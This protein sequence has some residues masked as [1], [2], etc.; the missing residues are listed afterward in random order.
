[1]RAAYERIRSADVRFVVRDGNRRMRG[2]LV[3]EK[4]SVVRA[5]LDVEDYG[6]VRVTSD[7]QTIEVADPDFPGGIERLPWTLQNAR[8]SIAANLEVISL[9]DAP[10]Q[11]ST[12]EGGNM[13][14]SDLRI[15]ESE[16]WKGKRWTIL[17][18]KSGFA[19]YRYF[20]DP[21]TSLMWRTTATR[22]EGTVAYDGQ[23]ERLRV[24]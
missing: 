17:E 3:Y 6:L 14:G 18:E 12:G 7:G 15:G 13:T 21:S 11:L 16:M 10:R 4:P 8:Q 20:I 5:T 2:A 24:R 9:W 1:M 19:L 23:I 22:P